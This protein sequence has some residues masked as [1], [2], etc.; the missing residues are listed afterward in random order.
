M[1]FRIRDSQGN[2]VDVQLCINKKGTVYFRR[3]PYTY[4]NP[5]E[6]QEEVRMRFAEAVHKARGMSRD[7]IVKSIAEAFSDWKKLTPEDKETITNEIKR[8]YPTDW[9]KLIRL[10]SLLEEI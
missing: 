1:R 6:R 8:L 9:E 10:L 7:E 2:D 4:H 3:I 5:T